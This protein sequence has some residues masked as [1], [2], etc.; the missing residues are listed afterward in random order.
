M[1]VIHTHYHQSNTEKKHGMDST[2]KLQNKTKGKY[3]SHFIE[4]MASKLKHRNLSQKKKR[5]KKI[6]QT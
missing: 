1:I 2:I 6:K 4:L 5:K 3:F